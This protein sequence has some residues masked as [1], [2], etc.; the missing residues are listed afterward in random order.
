MG[1]YISVEI[2]KGLMKMK[3]SIFFLNNR[4]TLYRLKSAFSILFSVL[5]L[6]YIYKL[7]TMFSSGHLLNFTTMYKC[8]Y[9]I[10]YLDI[11]NRSIFFF[12]FCFI[13][14]VFVSLQ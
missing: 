14:L 11:C 6:F 1:D 7:L 8:I 10:I 2:T 5:V 3:I 13:D 12:K 4:V 9:C